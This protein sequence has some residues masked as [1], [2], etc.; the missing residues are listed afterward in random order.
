[1]G[2]LGSAQLADREQCSQRMLPG[3]LA[4]PQLA[5]V[6]DS[7]LMEPLS[8]EATYFFPR[9]LR[10]MKLFPLQPEHAAAVARLADSLYP[11]GFPMSPLDIAD[12][13]ASLTPEDSF[14][15]GIEEDGELVAFL[16]AWRDTSQIEGRE[17][18]PI[19]LVDDMC[20]TKKHRRHI[21]TLLRQL[22]IGLRER[23]IH[24]IPL[25]G[26]HRVEA[27]NLFVN[28]ARVVKRLGYERVAQSSFDSEHGERLIWTRYE[29]AG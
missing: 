10:G 16:M 3:G 26:T 9:T 15:W 4:R 11:S 6:T 24:G 22:E 23:G 18:E 12:N 29:G 17:G 21:Y 14:C 13:L 20:A 28:H 5:Q 1:M 7:V 2:F 8:P 27:D 19:V 25:E